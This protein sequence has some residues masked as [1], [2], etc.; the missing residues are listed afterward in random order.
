MI[1]A[2]GVVTEPDLAQISGLISPIVS[3]IGF[4]IFDIHRAKLDSAASAALLRLKKQCEKS[5]LK[6]LVVSPGFAGA[7]FP[8]L[9]EAVDALK[10]SDGARLIEIFAQEG[11]LRKAQ[12]LAKQG[13]L[14]LLFKLGVTGDSSTPLEPAIRALEERH[15]LLRQLYK[16]LASEILRLQGE[17]EIKMPGSGNSGAVRVAEAKRRALDVVTGSG[18]LD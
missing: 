14:Q 10:S 4:V 17:N 13:R 7:D 18:V 15:E 3:R 16:T 11:A 9:A 1:N 8:A 2:D 5:K 6:F 12:L